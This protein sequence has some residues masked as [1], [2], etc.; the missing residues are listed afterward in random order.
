MCRTQQR[1]GRRCLSGIMFNEFGLKQIKLFFLVVLTPLCLFAQKIKFERQ[2]LQAPKKFASQ[3]EGSF[4]IDTI[5][6]FLPSSVGKNVTVLENGYAIAEIKNPASWKKTQQFKADTVSF[7]YTQYPKDKSFWLTDYNLLLAER[8]KALFKLDSTLNIPSVFYKIILQTSCNS[9]KEARQMFHGITIHVS[10]VPDVDSLTVRRTPTPENIAPKSSP[11]GVKKT[12]ENI[13]ESKKIGSFINN[14]GGMLDSTVYN[15]FDR[16]P[17]WKKTLVVMDWTGSMYPYGGQAVL[18]HSLNFKTSGMKYFVFFNDGNAE[19]R[20]KIGRTRGIY[21]EKAENLKKVISLL[22]KV[23]T[24]GNGGD[25]EEND[26]EAILKG[27]QKYPDFENLVLIA[28]NN[29]CIRDFCL[30]NELKVPVKIIL[31]GTYAGIN[32]QFLNLAYKT[33]GSI[34]TIEDDIYDIY[35]QTKSDATILIDGTEYRFN[36]K[37][38]LFEYTI[39]PD[40]DDPHYC[41]PFYKKKNCHCEKIIN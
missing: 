21:F 10:P 35:N 20:K 28:D 22:S 15:V 6:V 41:E 38:D 34:H 27:I 30:I 26:I 16:H 29:S 18:W 33:G 25:T 36:T 31:C 32:P 24:K 3:L 11:V 7:V 40:K 9:D 17:E 39:K 19:K 5:H 23:K 37:R 14:N 2:W 13:L 12:E 4:A 1:Q 8:L